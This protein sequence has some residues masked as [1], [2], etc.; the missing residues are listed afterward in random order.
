MTKVPVAGGQGR[1]GSGQ[2]ARAPDYVGAYSTSGQRSRVHVHWCSL[3]GI[4]GV[5]LNAT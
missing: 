1:A 3:I 5:R 4:F 2:V